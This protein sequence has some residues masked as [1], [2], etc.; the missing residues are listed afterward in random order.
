MI[1]QS[2]LTGHKKNLVNV[3]YKDKDK[4]AE[5]LH[6]TPCKSHSK[7]NENTN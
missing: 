1:I 4:A 2:Y 6:E 7:I 3:D 5:L